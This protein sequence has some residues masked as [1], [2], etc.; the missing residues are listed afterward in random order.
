MQWSV[1]QPVRAAKWEIVPT[2][3]VDEMYTDNVSLS[4]NDVKQDSWVT[5]VGPALS[6]DG[7]GAQLKF[8][9]LYNPEVI[10]YSRGD[11]DY[12]VYQRGDAF[13]TAELAKQLLY[14]DSGANVNQ[15][16]VSL[17]GPISTS[18]DNLTGN[19]ATV[20]TYF[21]SPYLRRD[22]GSQVQ[23]EARYTYSVVNAGAQSSAS[24]SVLSDSVA[25]RANLHLNSGP[26]YK[27]LSWNVDFVAEKVDYDS[28]EYTAS[29]V[30]TAN[31]RRLVTPTIGLL[32]QVGY[33]DYTSE[34]HSIDLAPG[35]DGLSWN[36]G[37]EWTPSPRTHFA[38]TIGHRF[39]GNAYS[40]DFNHR[41]RLTTWG[42]NYGERITTARSEFSA[43]ATASTAAF[44]DTLFTAQFP[45]PVT[46]QRAVQDFIARTGLPPSL[47]DPINFFSTQLLVVKRWQASSGILG[48][49]N[50]FIVDVYRESR[51]ALVGNFAFPGAGDFATS[52]NIIQT[53]ASFLWNLRLDA[54]DSWNTRASY[55]RNEFPGL[56]QIDHFVYLG[57]GVSRQF[58]PRLSGSLDV[59]NQHSYSNIATSYREN[60]VI[61]SVRMRF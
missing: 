17:H 27:V 34:Y 51:E 19:R 18:N 32:A 48:V 52:N 40:L 55:S 42:V 43:P 25:N 23:G 36:T 56:Q 50:V 45:D 14:V 4:P 3:S 60:A 1:C 12:K 31:V 37:L 57:V 26:A 11:S 13:G 10:Y 15:Y 2:M 49:R 21:A 30:A 33:E 38:A 39:Y 20:W 46:R 22:F 7:T 29:Q 44:L 24:N 9:A 47:T 35:T 5:T 53:G 54:R 6:V 59:R 16:D 28:G 41:T 61:A 8:K 58:E